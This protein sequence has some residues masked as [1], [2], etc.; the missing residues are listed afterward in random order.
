MP[1]NRAMKLSRL[2]FIIAAII[3]GVWVF[4][5]LLRLGAWII[6][7][8]LYIAAVIVI[9]GVVRYWWESRKKSK[10]ANTRKVVDAEIVEPKE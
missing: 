3:V 7:S 6:N 10:T 4:G 2:I 1:Y 9:I 5:L 8:L